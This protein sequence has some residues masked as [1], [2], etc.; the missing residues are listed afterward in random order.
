MPRI[1]SFLAFLSVILAPVGCLNKVD[2]NKD[3]VSDFNC[4]NNK[5]VEKVPNLPNIISSTTNCIDLPPLTPTMGI[6]TAGSAP[7][8]RVSRT[9]AHRWGLHSCF[10]L[11]ALP[12]AAMKE[13]QDEGMREEVDTWR[14]RLQRRPSSLAQLT[15]AVHRQCSWLGIVGEQAVASLALSIFACCWRERERKRSVTD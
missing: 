12:D 1:I 13:G 3:S 9:S 4:L 6:G 15:A 7:P 14:L 10:S 2:V 11:C 8:P 5:F